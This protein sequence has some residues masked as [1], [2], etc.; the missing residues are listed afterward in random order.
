MIFRT[1]RVRRNI[2]ACKVSFNSFSRTAHP[3]PFLVSSHIFEKPSAALWPG[4]ACHWVPF[5]SDAIDSFYFFF[6]RLSLLRAVILSTPRSKIFEQFFDKN[7]VTALFDWRFWWCFP[8]LCKSR[9]QLTSLCGSTEFLDISLKILSQITRTFYVAL[10]FPW[11]K[12]LSCDPINIKSDLRRPSSWLRSQRKNYFN[13]SRLEN[14]F[15]M[16]S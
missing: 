2:V 5:S 15:Y 13:I 12:I 14:L 10:C 4:V 6:E 7:D 9:G 11:S 16:I 8:V 3:T 1:S